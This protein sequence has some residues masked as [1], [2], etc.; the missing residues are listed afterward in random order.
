MDK[1]SILAKKDRAIQTVDVPEWECAV[2]IV[3]FS[4]TVRNE[5]DKAFIGASK[6]GK[7]QDPAAIKFLAIVRSVCDSDGNLLFDVADIPELEKKNANAL[8]RIWEAVEALNY[9]ADVKKK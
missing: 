3:P 6:D 2:N 5:L 4:G 9:I 1:F 7:I 8:N